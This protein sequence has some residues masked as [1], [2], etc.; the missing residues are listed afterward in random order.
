MNKTDKLVGKATK[1]CPKCDGIGISK[2]IIRKNRQTGE[3]FH[4]CENW[5]DCTYTEPLSE[6]Y[7]MAMLNHPRLFP[8]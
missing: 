7:R 5:P 6:E 4:G 8:D 3:L 1:D 2:L